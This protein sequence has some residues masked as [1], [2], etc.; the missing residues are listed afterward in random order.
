MMH[1]ICMTLWIFDKMEKMMWVDFES[2]YPVY[3]IL[4]E[5]YKHDLE[6]KRKKRRKLGI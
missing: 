4:K 6:K 5:M 2:F 3:F 1:A